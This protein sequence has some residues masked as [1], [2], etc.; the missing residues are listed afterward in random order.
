MFIKRGMG[1]SYMDYNSAINK[2][3]IS[4]KSI[5]LNSHLEGGNLDPERQR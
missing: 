2:M 3:R 5:E 4:G 1:N